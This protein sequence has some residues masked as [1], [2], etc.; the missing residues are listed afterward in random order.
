[1]SRIRCTTLA[2]IIVFVTTSQADTRSPEIGDGSC[3]VRGAVRC[4]LANATLSDL[5]LTSVELRK[6]GDISELFNRGNYSTPI[7]VVRFATRTNLRGVSKQL[8][9]I[10]ANQLLVG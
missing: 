9:G 1:M 7:F 3:I 5:T 4:D 10:V 2:A 8:G 6:L